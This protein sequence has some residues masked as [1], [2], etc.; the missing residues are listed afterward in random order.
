M[1]KANNWPWKK[2]G[3]TDV[4]MA[5]TILT[6]KQQSLLD[7]LAKQL[8]QVNT[9]KDYPYM[10]KNIINWSKKFWGKWDTTV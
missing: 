6:L 10:I 7:F 4:V 3:F 5:Q 1:E 2:K 8:L 9:L